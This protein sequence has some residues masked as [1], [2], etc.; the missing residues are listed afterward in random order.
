MA[1]VERADQ[2]CTDVA[3]TIERT[4]SAIHSGIVKP[5][6]EGRAVILGIQAVIAAIREFRA[7]RAQSRRKEDEDGLFI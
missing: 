6:R 4:L 1:Q 2:V 3:Q 7:Q 5:A